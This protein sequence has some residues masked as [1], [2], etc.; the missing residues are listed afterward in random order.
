MIF[1]QSISVTIFLLKLCLCHVMLRVHHTAYY[2]VKFCHR[3]MTSQTPG[4]EISFIK[5][6]SV[7]IRYFNTQS[8]NYSISVSSPHVYYLIY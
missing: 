3:V 2:S 8:N 6:C 5:I 4:S 1:Y 7:L